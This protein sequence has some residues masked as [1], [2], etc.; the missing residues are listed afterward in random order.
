MKFEHGEHNEG[1]SDILLNYQDKPYNDWVVTTSFY[2]CIQ[3]VEHKIFPREIDGEQYDN[4]NEYCD[5]QHNVLKNRTS[6][7]D[8]KT[9]LVK[10][11]IPAVHAQYRHLKDLCFNSRY[12]NYIV[13]DNK[14]TSANITMKV[15]KRNC[16]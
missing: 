13:S 2:A 12:N 16:S 10:K 15:I 1:L 9:Q 4:F 5:Y 7:H 8:L 3:F 6:K 11:F 14:A